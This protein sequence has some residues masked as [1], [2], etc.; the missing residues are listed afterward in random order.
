[1]TRRR[2]YDSGTSR[3]FSAPDIVRFLAFRPR[4]STREIGDYLDYCASNAMTTLYRL[5]DRGIIKSEIVSR[6]PAGGNRFVRVRLWS[7]APIPAAEHAIYEERQETDEQVVRLFLERNS[8]WWTQREISEAISMSC[9]V[10]SAILHRLVD[11]GA[12]ERDKDLMSV[13]WRDGYREQRICVY[14]LKENELC[15]DH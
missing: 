12:V 3:K 4:S 14:R 5:E 10:V 2:E 11:A 1:M 6:K 7:L 9:Q 8:G 15:Q 13:R